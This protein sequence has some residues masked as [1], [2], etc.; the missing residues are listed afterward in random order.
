MLRQIRRILEL[1][2]LCHSV[3]SSKVTELSHRGLKCI[4]CKSRHH[5]NHSKHQHPNCVLWASQVSMAVISANLT[6]HHPAQCKA[7]DGV[8]QTLLPINSGAVEKCSVKFLIVR[9]YPIVWV[10]R[11][12]NARRA[13]LARLHCAGKFS[14]E[15]IQAMG[16]F[17]WCLPRPLDFSDGKS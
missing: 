11:W 3:W 17:S 15:R 12:A 14:G 7:L 1:S 10:L 5:Q 8:L 13:L 2:Q 6:L 4:M 9:F 16:F